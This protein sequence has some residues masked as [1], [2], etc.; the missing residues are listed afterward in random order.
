MPIPGSPLARTATAA[1]PTHRVVPPGCLRQQTEAP[2][3]QGARAPPAVPP[4]A[5]RPGSRPA[6]SRGPPGRTSDAGSPTSP[7]FDRSH[8]RDQLLPTP[9]ALPRHTAE[10]ASVEPVR[11]ALRAPPTPAVAPPGLAPTPAPV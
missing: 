4:V 7:A 1:R 11:L 6:A 8:R 9:P 5:L 3:P 10:P 2:T